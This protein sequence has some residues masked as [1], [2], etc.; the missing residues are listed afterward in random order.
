MYI[1]V[2]NYQ[3]LQPL[4][5]QPS[6]S[7]ENLLSSMSTSTSS[8]SSKRMSMM[9]GRRM[10]DIKRSLNT[11]IHKSSSTRESML[12]S[13]EPSVSDGKIFFN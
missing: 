13:D 12:F 5:N 8:S 7:D 10:I 4:Q 9:G 11:M 1:S 2:K 3:I 6:G